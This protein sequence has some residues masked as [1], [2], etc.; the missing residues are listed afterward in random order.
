MV[1]NVLHFDVHH[2]VMSNAQVSFVHK[3]TGLP[4]QAGR[5]VRTLWW[6]SSEH[7][8]RASALTERKFGSR[9]KPFLST[10]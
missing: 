8:K 7:Q 3:K 5:G 1:P 6:E 10:L 2:Q 9:F 4:K